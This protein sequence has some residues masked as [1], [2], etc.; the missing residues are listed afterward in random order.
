MTVI[1]PKILQVSIGPP[2]SPGR[3]WDQSLYIK[4]QITR[5]AGSTPN[6]AKVEIYNLAPAS[7]AYIERPGNVLQIRAG[8]TVPGTLFYGE[9]R[10]SG[11][12]T[13]IKHPN[14]ITELKATDGLRLMQ[15]GYFI[16]S[17]PAGTTRSQIVADVLAQNAVARGYVAPIPERTYHAPIMLSN[18]IAE[19]LDELYTGESADW[20]IQDARFNLLLDGQ[21]LPGNAPIVSAET[22]MIG[23]PERTDKGI[24]VKFGAVG[25]VRPGGGF[26]LKSRLTSGTYKAAKIVTDIDTELKWE[27]SITGTVIK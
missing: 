7:V 25:V 15:T 11:I 14:Q 26:V 12:R 13:S 5:T 9:L 2:A 6:K 8:E 24:K 3:M 4:A 27:D 19:V 16:G 10:T 18:P 22:G 23:S 1:A 21:T 20:S 17:Y